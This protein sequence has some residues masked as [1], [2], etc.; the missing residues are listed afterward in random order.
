M[1]QPLPAGRSDWRRWLWVLYAGLS[2]I[3][4]QAQNGSEVCAFTLLAPLALLATQA[5][6]WRRRLLHLLTVLFA[7]ALLV[8][9]VGATYAHATV[10]P[11]YAAVDLPRM[12]G[13]F[14]L[15]A[16]DLEELRHGVAL[17]SKHRVRHG[18]LALDRETY[19]AAFLDIAPIP[20]RLW[21]LHPGRTIDRATAPPAEAMFAA[22]DYVLL[23][24]DGEVDYLQRLARDFLLA[25]Y[26]R[27]LRETYRLLDED[28][29]WELWQR[30]LPESAS[31]RAFA[32]DDW[33]A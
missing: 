11:A 20:G 23:R 33:R 15:R 30:K 32:R 25:V 3:A 17:L 16:D 9:Q 24:K 13:V 12:Q 21:C 19:F 7:S 1:Q 28:R 31:R 6:G 2:T 18:L 8:K 10:H 27:Y 5:G 14:Y 4:I 26:G 29:Y 22:A